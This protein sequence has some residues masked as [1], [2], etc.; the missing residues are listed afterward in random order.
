MSI[1]YCP[2]MGLGYRRKT[3][4]AFFS[5]FILL[6][7]R[8]NRVEGYF[9]MGS[10]HLQENSGVSPRKNSG[11][12]QLESG[13]YFFLYA[14]QKHGE[15]LNR[16]EMP[17]AFTDISRVVEAES[18]LCLGVV[19]LE[20]STEYAQAFQRYTAWIGEKRHA[21][22]AWL[23]AHAKARRD[24]HT[25][26]VGARTAVI[27]AL[28]YAEEGARTERGPQ[29][30][31]YAR[32]ADYHKIL[33]KKGERIV[34][35][36]KGLSLPLAA[37]F[38]V[39]VDTAP[40]LER[41]LAASTLR[42]FIGKNTCYIH[43]ER[44]SFL[45][46]GE[47][48]TSLPLTPDTKVPVDENRRTADGGCGSCDLCQVSCP[49]GALSD[50][51]KIDA[52]KCL[53]YWTIEHRGPIPERFWPWLGSYYYGCDL[54]Q[55][56]C[57][58]NWRATGNRLPSQIPKRIYPSLYEVAIMSQSAYENYFGGTA[59]T[60]AK[61]NGLRRNALIAMTVTRDFLLAKAL[62]IVKE[63]CPSPLAETLIQ[64]ENYRMKN[65]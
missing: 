62:E 45:L 40:V 46:L 1:G 22:M 41:A 38:R 43:P 27:F 30:A 36:L 19:S 24:P 8:P 47:I 4:Y 17:V 64:I 51:Y 39:I 61:R 29:V 20:N 3:Q 50:D 37:D 28:P 57:P 52:K 59:L 5:F 54:C 13:F 48:L 35:G 32:F 14:S 42:G 11:R 12:N 44:G 60:R 49:T 58:Y 16:L 65:I 31:Q 53:S 2:I 63:D 34:L 7:A 55:L 23:E 9:G 25:I 56:A 21:E 15:P 26:L 10:Y 33:K 6:R 18:L